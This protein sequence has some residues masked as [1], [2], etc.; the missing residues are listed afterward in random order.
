MRSIV[1][2]AILPALAACQPAVVEPVPAANQAAAAEEGDI[3]LLARTNCAGCHAVRA[4]DL[5]PLPSAP[6][7]VEI[8]NMPGLTRETVSAYL[9]DAHNYPDQMDIELD[10]R[11]VAAIAEYLLT[12]RSEDYKRRPS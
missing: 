8:A 1:L 4:G 11:D 3:P 2:A 5:S 6:S 7:F 10:A 9:G 12:L